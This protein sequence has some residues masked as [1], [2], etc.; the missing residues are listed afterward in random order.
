MG[1][2]CASSSPKAAKNQEEESSTAD[3]GA[4]ERETRL[5]A[6]V[7][8]LEAQL[9]ASKHAKGSNEQNGEEEKV[10]ASTPMYSELTVKDDPEE[11]SDLRM[12]IRDLKIRLQRSEASANALK[13]AAS[14]GAEQ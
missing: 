10:P 11:D 2:Q 7:A 8:E 1:Q 12:Q 13:S 6:R 14:R 3:N 9:E 5:K 4:G